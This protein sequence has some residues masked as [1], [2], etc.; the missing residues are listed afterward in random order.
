[1]LPDLE[2]DIPLLEP[3]PVLLEQLAQLSATSVAP[4]GGGPVRT[5]VAAVTVVVVGGFSW[6][7]GTLPGVA[8]PFDGD[9]GPAPQH[10]PADPGQDGIDPAGDPGA[11]GPL[12]VHSGRGSH[13]GQTRP[14]QPD[15]AAPSQQDSGN[16][17]GQIKPHTDNGNHTGQIK[18][19]TNNG[20]HTG[21]IKPHT[22]NGNHTG[23]TK[24][25]EGTGDETGQTKPHE[26]NGNHTGP[27]ATPQDNGNANGHVK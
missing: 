6:L 18:P 2:L 25:D 13:A 20:N 11:P 21:Q 22:D 26:D 1:M 3:D 5:L 15:G 14:H 16:H 19:H 7:T 23:Q 9:G 24:P 12:E 8:S 10:A 4:A 27:T 17:T